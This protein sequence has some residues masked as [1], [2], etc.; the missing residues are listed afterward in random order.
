MYRLRSCS[1]CETKDLPLTRDHHYE[2][3]F[4][5]VWS[6]GLIYLDYDKN[7]KNKVWLFITGSL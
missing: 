5:V 2:N 4:Y 7:A 6:L 1:I 3:F